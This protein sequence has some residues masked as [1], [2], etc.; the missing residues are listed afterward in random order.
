LQNRLRPLRHHVGRR[1]DQQIVVHQQLLELRQ[2]AELARQ[3][4]QLSAADIQLTSAPRLP[5]SGGRA[6]N[7]GM[8]VA[9]SVV[10]ARRLPIYGG[11][12]AI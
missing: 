3:G 2:A 7:D 5:I 1:R 11:S 8:F 10:S 12:G 6:V 9:S 4:G